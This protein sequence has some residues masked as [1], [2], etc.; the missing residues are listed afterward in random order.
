MEVKKN[1]NINKGA[2][3][4]SVIFILLFF[5]LIG[6]FFYIQVTKKI[7]GEYLE[8]LAE[9]KWTKTQIIDANR[10][11]IY[12]RTGQPLAQDIPAYTV[13]AV[14]DENYPNHVKDPNDT[15][16]KLAKVL[17]GSKEKFK[18]ILEQ[19]RFQVEF[20]SSGRKITHSQKEAIEKLKLPGIG[21]IREKKR[22]YP[23]QVFASHILG[24]TNT[25]TEKEIEEGVMGLEQSLNKH[26]SEQNGSV[27]FQSDRKG[28]ILPDEE[29]AITEPKNGKDVY[30][31]LDEKIQLFLE[32]ALKKADEQ[33]KP[34]RMIGIVADPT[35]GQILGM[36]SYPSFDPNQRN[37]TD[38]TNYGVSW[39]FEPGS[40]MKVFTLAAAIEA[41]VYNG[42]EQFQSGSYNKIPNTKPIQDHNYGRGWGTITF[43]EG[44]QNS[45]NVAISILVNE[46]LGVDRYYEYIEKFGLREKTGIDLP[47]EQN[48][49]I[50]DKWP[51]DKVTTGF[52]Q[53]SIITPIQQVQAFTA[54]ANGG[55][56]MQPYVIDKIVDP[57]TGDAVKESK[58]T[59]K[60]EPISKET[61]QEVRDILR[62]VVTDGTGT[63]FEIEGYDVA[64]KTGTA[65]IAENGK[66]L[67]GKGNYVY[68]FLGLAPK[69]K[70]ELIVY[71]AVDRPHLEPYEVDST[72]TSQ[73]FTYVMKNSLQYLNI[74]PN[75]KNKTSNTAQKSLGIELK[76]YQGKSVQSAKKELISQGFKVEIIG[77]GKEII[78]QI[79]FSG[80]KILD[81]ERIILTSNGKMTMPDLTN[82]SIADVMKA[83]SALDVKVSL[84][85]SGYATKQSIAP[86]Q[87]V[88]K[89]DYLVVEL[90][91]PNPNDLEPHVSI[92]TD[93]PVV[94]D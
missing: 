6:R 23:D 80:T 3:V 77:D 66:Y 54:V 47:G 31:T 59:V 13:Y 86:G 7:E 53:G 89:E 17:G 93:E 40:T 48:S 61:A 21:F 91:T 44:I 69:D 78:N 35:T 34:E 8:E 49:T 11:T 30:L 10:G 58:P 94:K 75:E 56:M 90:E 25:N 81:G 70:P 9:D 88:K 29:A 41:G 83:A 71:V 84:I 92:Q 64:G 52:G 87:F 68:S 57:V 5:L 14:L 85:G 74:K 22:F 76:N 39:A 26:L 79:P 18:Q 19:D 55:K 73:I 33:Y 15:A 1:P 24:F 38:Y 42:N 72:V 43:N 2:A 62:T 12:D 51:R 32:T 36:S 46:K 45:S 67:T 20:G 65:Q 82:W 16:E 28:I 27:T 4:L 37:I 60:G 50:L 63:L